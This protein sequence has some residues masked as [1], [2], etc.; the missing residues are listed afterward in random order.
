MKKV[1][2][3]ANNL[4]KDVL[5]YFGDHLSVNAIRKITN[6]RLFNE[7]SNNNTVS[8]AYFVEINGNYGFMCD[9]SKMMNQHTAN[10]ICQSL[11]HSKA[12]TGEGT[13]WFQKGKISIRFKRKYYFS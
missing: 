9:R 10:L 12:E 1:F 4:Q 2:I 13:G 11:G 8:G 7:T 3:S 5:T 6:F